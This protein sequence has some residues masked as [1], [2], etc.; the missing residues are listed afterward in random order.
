M[1]HVIL[2]AGR[3]LRP[4]GV[5]EFR[6]AVAGITQV[7]PFTRVRRGRLERVK[8][9]P[10][11]KVELIKKLKDKAWKLRDLADKTEDHGKIK[12]YYRRANGLEARARELEEGRVTQKEVKEIKSKEP[13]EKDWNHDRIREWAKDI[14]RDLIGEVQG[15]EV[16]DEMM[17]ETAKS[18]L[19][20]EPS[21]RK[22]LITDRGLESRQAMAEWV[23]DEIA[24][25]VDKHIWD[26]VTKKVV[27]NHDFC[28]H[29]G[30]TI[31]HSNGDIECLGCKEIVGKRFSRRD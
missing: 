17:Y 9:Y 20:M 7:K 5:T 12:S 4:E 23:S 15:G 8:G 3:L 2:K 29:N 28:P 25:Q 24:S 19:L 13:K 18:Y 1:L 21:I 11:A 14:A 16:S 22:Y 30:P 27:S 31:T 6:T 10:R 26:P